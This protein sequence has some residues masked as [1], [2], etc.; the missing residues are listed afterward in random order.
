MLTVSRAAFL[1]QVVADPHAE[2]DGAVGLW[3]EVELW[4][5]IGGGTS[6]RQNISS[7]GLWDIDASGP[8]D[9]YLDEVYAE[10]VEQLETILGAL[11]VLIL[12]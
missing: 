3:A 12:A 5:P 10:E 2:T 8:N 1:R 6:V 11:G 7:G 9:P 4:I